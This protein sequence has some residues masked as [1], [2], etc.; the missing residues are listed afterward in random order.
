MYRQTIKKRSPLSAV[1]ILGLLITTA[2]I[3]EFPAESPYD[4]ETPEAQQAPAEIS[5]R[6]VPEIAIDTTQIQVLVEGQGA[7]ASADANGAFQ[8]ELSAGDYE[9][10]IQAPDHETFIV[11]SVTLGTGEKRNLGQV[12]LVAHKGALEGSVTLTDGTSSAGTLINVSGVDRSVL[13]NQ[14]G[15][16]Q[17]SDLPI[18][19]YNLVF[20]KEGYE[21]KLVSGI[22]VVQGETATVAVTLAKL[23]GDGDFSIQDNARYT[24]NRTI[25]LNFAGFEF[26]R[27]QASETSDFA[28]AASPSPIQNSSADF[29]LSA[30]DGEKRVYVRFTENDSEPY[31]YTRTYSASIILDQTAPE[32][33]SAELANNAEYT[34]R[35]DVSLV[36]NAFDQWSGVSQMQLVLDGTADDESWE[37][38]SVQNNLVLPNSSSDGEKLIQV[39]VRDLVGNESA[40]VEKRITL[41]TVAPSVNG[42]GIVINGGATHTQSRDV[43]LSFDVSGASSVKVYNQGAA[44]QASWQAYPAEGRLLWSLPANTS[45]DPTGETKTVT[46]IF[47]DAAGNETS[48]YSD[49][50]QLD[51]VAPLART[52]SLASGNVEV[53]STNVALSVTPALTGTDLRIVL[54]GPIDEA[55]TYT[56]STL[57][58]AVTLQGVDGQKLVRA[59][60]LDAADNESPSFGDSV[61]LDRVAP[62]VGNVILAAGVTS[63]NQTQVDWVLVPSLLGSNLTVRLSGDILESGTT[64][65]SANVPAQLTLTNGDGNKSVSAVLIDAA[66]NESASFGDTVVLDTQAPILTG[67]GLTIAQGDSH[68]SQRQV[69]LEFTVTGA[70]QLRIRNGSSSF[71][72]YQN[73][74]ANNQTV[75]TLA[76]LSSSAPDGETKTVV[77][78]Y[79]DAAGN[80]T[81]EASATI[82][83]DSVAPETRTA[84]LDSGAQYTNNRSVTFNIAPSI[85]GENLSVVLGGDI[86]EA[87]TYG[88]GAEPSQLTLS[89][90]DGV[91]AVTVVLIDQAGNQ[92]LPFT[93]TIELDRQAPQDGVVTVAEGRNVTNSRDVAISIANTNPDTMAF[94][95]VGSASACL[96]RTCS[97]PS[98]G[99]FSPSTSFTL[100]EQRGNKKLCWQ[101]C[102]EAG[103]A[104]NVGQ[105]SI[106]LGTYLPRPRPILTSI[107]PTNYVAF[108]QNSY[109]LTV[110]GRGI[111]SDTQVKVGAFTYPCDISGSG[112]NCQ[113]DSN[114]GCG[115]TGTCATTCSLSCSI[116]LDENVMANSGTYV[117][118]VS[119]PDP[120]VN[121][122]NESSDVAFFSVVAPVPE[123]LNI[124]P[125]GVVQNLDASG[126][127]IA[128][129]VDVTLEVRD[130]TQNVSFKLG[131]NFG[132]VQS[133]E[134]LPSGTEQFVVTFT[135]GSL[136]PGDLIETEI[137]A[138]NPAPGGGSSTSVPFGLSP[139][140][141]QCPTFGNCQS[142]LRRTRVDVGTREGGSLSTAA[143]ELTGESLQGVE[144]NYEISNQDILGRGAAVRGADVISVSAGQSGDTNGGSQADDTL[145]KA[146]SARVRQVNSGGRTPYLF[147]PMSTQNENYRKATL[148]LESEVPSTRVVHFATASNK[149]AT[150]RYTRR[151]TNGNTKFMGSGGVLDQII[152]A[153][154]QAD[155]LPSYALRNTS[156]V[157]VSNMPQSG[158]LGNAAIPF[159]SNIDIEFSGVRILA[160]DDLNGDNIVDVIGYEDSLTDALVIIPGKGDGTFEAQITNTQISLGW[161]AQVFDFNRD[162][163]PDIVTDVNTGSAGRNAVV[164]LNRGNLDFER[165]ASLR[166]A[167][168]FDTSQYSRVSNFH[169]ATPVDLNNDGYLDLVSDLHLWE[170]SGRV[171]RLSY[172]VAA[173]GNGDG[174]F[175][176]FEIIW[177]Y[178][179]QDNNPSLFREPC[180]NS[181]PQFFDM[182][183]DARLDLVR[184]CDL[185]NGIRPYVFLGDESGSF[186]TMLEAP[187]LPDS[188]VT[189]VNNELVVLDMNEDSIPDL[190]GT[191]SYEFGATVTGEYVGLVTFFG[192]GDGSFDIPTIAKAE[193]FI[194]TANA[195]NYNPMALLTSVDF[196]LDG[197]TEFIAIRNFGNFFVFE[198]ELSSGGPD[199][200]LSQFPTDFYEAAGFGD[201]D[202]DGVYDYFRVTQDNV[203]L[204][205]GNGD[206]TFDTENSVY[207]DS[208]LHSSWD[209]ISSDNYYPALTADIDGD[210]HLDIAFDIDVRVSSN[211][212]VFERRTRIIHGDG[213]GAFMVGGWSTQS[214]PPTNQLAGQRLISICPLAHGEQPSVVTVSGDTV[215]AYQY[216]DVPTNLQYRTMV[217][218]S[219]ITLASGEIP[220]GIADPPAHCAD[221]NADGHMDLLINRERPIPNDTSP[222]VRGPLML[223]GDGAGNLV[224]ANIGGLQNT[225]VTS[226]GDFNRDGWLDLLVRTERLQGNGDTCLWGNQYYY[227][228]SAATTLS[229]TQ[230]VNPYSVED[231]LCSFGGDRP[232]NIG[233]KNSVAQDIDG[234]GNT[235][236]VMWSSWSSRIELFPNEKMGE[237]Y[238]GTGAKLPEHTYSS[239]FSAEFGA[240]IQVPPIVLDLNQDQT[241]DIVAA[242]NLWIL[243][244]ARTWTQELRE[245]PPMSVVIPQ[246]NS[247]FRVF[248]RRQ[249]VEKLAVAVSLAGA[250]LDNLELRLRSPN[251][252]DVIR[253]D[254]TND[255][256]GL[257]EAY[258][259]YSVSDEDFLGWQKAG[260]W[261]LDVTN[262]STQAIQLVDFRIVTHGSFYRPM[263]GSIVD[264]PRRVVFPAG[265][266]GRH[267]NGTTT[268]KPDTF[269]VTCADT[270]TNTEGS[271]SGE[272]WH[273]FDLRNPNQL[274]ISGIADF[275]AAIELR[276]GACGDFGSSAVVGCDHNFGIA[277]RLELSNANLP[278]GTYC[279][280]V[281]GRYDSS[282]NERHSGTFDLSLRLQNAVP[283]VCG[284]GVLETGEVCDDG[285]TQ[286][287]DGCLSD[288]S[289]VEAGWSCSGSPSICSQNQQTLSEQEPNDDRTQA[290]SVGLF[291]TGNVTVDGSIQPNT[292]V[293]FWSVTVPALT[294][295][296]LSANIYG[297][298][299]V[300]NSCNG[301]SVMQ[302]QSPAGVI[303]TENDDIGTNNNL[304]SAVTN[305][306][307]D[308]SS[309]TPADFYIRI[310]SFGNGT[311]FSYLMDVNVQ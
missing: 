141:T 163:L 183:A 46:A 200:L 289:G 140:R 115:A 11:G 87:A 75:W 242:N 233:K 59:T 277:N 237:L 40:F 110:N 158:S 205:L 264:N 192:R 128:Q 154:L 194:D 161:N 256:S 55:G 298:P 32:L 249:H 241:P 260:A 34:S 270:S 278:A 268:S 265:S 57:P 153:H 236:M 134:Q 235:D 70:T 52:L 234:D 272:Y 139:A 201:F 104:S 197:H 31:T 3:P 24:S 112:T 296:N 274:S 78:Q 103:N 226:T 227:G 271:G 61:L 293:D 164:Y 149:K 37:A 151:S 5:A 142:L 281:D 130:A 38:F 124:E 261:A 105:Q 127:P 267:V 118:R 203:N 77:V 175:G 147:P 19:D 90:S 196:N 107:D 209:N 305:F 250:P 16:F 21:N 95:E 273:Q 84:E 224:Q 176:D 91:K 58:A 198:P 86:A 156:I 132:R 280:V 135:T 182:N 23:A 193:P 195:A 190:V 155:N 14:N 146:V 177:T 15:M 214:G 45:N 275:D 159:G 288:C 2:C 199:Y 56:A 43:Q 184:T 50:I 25:Q 9:I 219:V 49:D 231:V 4:P 239:A 22:N 26:P 180:K 137:L 162:G 53:N 309:P 51:A 306:T 41:D 302:I 114:G 245:M 96:L 30:E 42:G 1:S 74:P 206:G 286:S 36:L 222:G 294:S 282:S 285:N 217:G 308:N 150:G 27:Y 299:G 188:S 138:L 216:S 121:G 148:R 145:E 247:L 276:A 255:F 181:R 165:T 174:T 20:L 251:G 168:V 64:Y 284:N 71:G 73:L 47:R 291:G 189:L 301:D 89:D 220:A 218:G 157:S 230:A 69:T 215:S 72:A 48:P 113:A 269:D 258:V 79:R 178:A 85:S 223:L 221:F 111:A 279:L 117:V 83:L 94:W 67:A 212:S 173:Y 65:T 18:G 228:S 129:D 248:Q 106:E 60:L 29:E 238:D 186:T 35:S 144:Q 292:D 244:T 287:G 213:N 120:V 171:N 160:L 225:F 39:R 229:Q 88:I 109:T 246:G 310:Q 108:S 82:V 136:I 170:S 6:V 98:F 297:T 93:S 179:F 167:H 99:L 307:L 33:V 133:R 187:A 290:T 44:A 252:S 125:R 240:S 266:S 54:E 185:G 191:T 172:V 283:G 119:T 207:T 28:G 10:S 257:S 152:V 263:K 303:L 97:H 126:L 62:N 92:S 211:P 17:I 66:G 102:D 116:T 8:A 166:Y 253:L 13:V 304:C 210:G 7:I 254:R 76:A 243:P 63:T 122:L 300:P 202:S 100:S 204:S 232:S 143:L 101:F 68:T 169:Y 262:S 80:E 131:P 81:A 311:S 208:F 12:N 123:I 295:V 259:T